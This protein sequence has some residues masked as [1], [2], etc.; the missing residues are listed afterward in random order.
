MDISEFA[1][2]EDEIAE[3]L[4][5]E[6]EDKISMGEKVAKAQLIKIQDGIDEPR[7][8]LTAHRVPQHEIRYGTS[9]AE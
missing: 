1:L 4:G 3:A 6:R 5:G 2:N 8:S 7:H 9:G